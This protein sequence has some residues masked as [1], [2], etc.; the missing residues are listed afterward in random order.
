MKSVAVSSLFAAAVADMALTW[1]DC[2]DE[3]THAKISS[4][5]PDTLMTGQEVTISGIG[6]LDQDIDEAVSF[7]LAMEGQFTDCTGLASAG[8]KCNFP[9]NMGSIEF[10]GLPGP[11]TAGEIPIDVDLS[12]SRLLPATLLET[13]TQVTGIGADSGNLIFCMNV[14][15]KK[16]AA[17]KLGR[18]VLDVDWSDC[19]T[20]AGAKATITGLTP[21]QLTQGSVQHIEGKGVLAEDVQE[22][23]KFESSMRLAFLECDGDGIA[24][25]KCKFPLNLGSIEFKGIQTPIKAGPQQ[26][27]VDLKIGNLIPD[28]TKSTTH[29]T[30]VSESGKKLFCLDVNTDGKTSDVSV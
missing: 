24:G 25:K 14:Y 15:T 26:I 23:I 16:S 9:L 22:E 28:G 30:A 3:D 13:T 18:G 11:Y 10:K 21:S 29:V 6:N 17:S 7:S 4:V 5:T 2:G 20:D 1:S 27:D 12:I 19:G 8:A